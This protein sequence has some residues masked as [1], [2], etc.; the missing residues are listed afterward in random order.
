MIRNAIHTV[1]V[2]FLF[3]QETEGQSKWMAFTRVV[4]GNG[5]I[6]TMDPDGSMLTNL[7]NHPDYDDS[8]SWSPDGSRIAFNSQRE[9]GWNIFVMQADGSDP[10]NLTESIERNSRHLEW[11]PDGLQI[12]FASD[13][14]AVR[15]EGSF[16]WVPGTDILVMHADGS[17]IVNLTNNVFT[18]SDDPAWSPDGRKIVYSRKD[19]IGDD[20]DF[21]LFVMNSDG[22]NQTNI[23]NSLGYDS[24]PSWS[25]D[26][27]KIVFRSLR[28]GNSEVYVM[29]AD[30]TEQHNLTNHPSD[31]YSPSWSPDGVGI[32][33]SSDRDSNGEVYTEIFT[34]DTDGTDVS[35]LT[36]F[37]ITGSS[38]TWSPVLGSTV[39][40]PR[41][42]AQTKKEPLAR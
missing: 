22:T 17:N 23:I 39:V 27:R 2:V 12:A 37:P 40:Q 14:D 31:D 11:S 16:V 35:K 9:V 42:W 18:Y 20:A 32:V 38:P 1:L 36:V 33:F 28:D 8:P 15:P 5:E 13:R 21:D 25:P 26:G 34:M 29:N 7:T 19:D 30:G 4:D 10:T 3:V 24:S 41:S 6:Y